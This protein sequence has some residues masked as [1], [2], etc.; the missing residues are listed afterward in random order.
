[1]DDLLQE[2]DEGE[3]EDPDEIDEVPVE[4]GDLD[5]AVALRRVL[6]EEA[7]REDHAQVHDP[8]EHVHPVEPGEDEKGG[9]EE[10]LPNRLPLVEDELV[11]L[12]GLQREEDHPAE[13]RQEEKPA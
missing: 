4:G 11:P 5:L 8:R 10:V 7:A 6:A 9:A 2:V 13:D 12:E 1:M 3:D